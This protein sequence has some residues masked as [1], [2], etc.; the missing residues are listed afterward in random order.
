MKFDTSIVKAHYESPLGTMIVA[1]TPRGLA[2]VWF[3]GQRHLPDHSRWPVQADHPVLRQAQAQ[4][5]E[6]FAGTRNAFDLPLDLQGG[7]AFQ[8]SVWDA[9]LA[10]PR[11]GT[12]SY[13]TLSRIIGQ[14]ALV[15][16]Q[17]ISSGVPCSP[18]SFVESVTLLCRAAA[19]SNRPPIVPF[20]SEAA[21]LSATG[22][23]PAGE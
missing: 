9:L 17:I 15:H 21:F 6:Y 20:A 4:L 19:A 3:D 1:A 18:D 5:G 2:G 22:T 16:S 23:A 10:I 8:R 11:G 7:T 12:T 14:P 13:G